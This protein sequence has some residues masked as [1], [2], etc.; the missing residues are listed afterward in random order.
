M[1]HHIFLLLAMPFLGIVHVAGAEGDFKSLSLNSDDAPLA[2]QMTNEMMEQV[3]SLTISGFLRHEDFE[4]IDKCQHL[5]WL[6]LK[7]ATTDSI[8]VDTGTLQETECIHSNI[9]KGAF[10]HAPI[11]VLYLPENAYT[12][13]L[14]SLSLFRW[15][16]DCGRPA[17]D[18]ETTNYDGLPHFEKIIT[19]YITGDFPY[20]FDPEPIDGYYG[21]PML[22]KLSKDNKK[23]IE[24]DGNIYSFNKSRLLKAGN[25]ENKGSEEL[26]FDVQSVEPCAFTYSLWSIDSQLLTF[27]E[28]LHEIEY[29]AFTEVARPFRKE[30]SQNNIGGIR[31]EGWTPPRLSAGGFQL[32]NH[33]YYGID[34]NI[35]PCNT[36]V[37]LKSR[38]VLS[39]LRWLPHVMD[40]F[41]YGVL[42]G[43]LSVDNKEDFYCQQ[44]KYGPRLEETLEKMKQV[45]FRMEGYAYTPAYIFDERIPEIHMNACMKRFI[46]FSFVNPNN[47]QKETLVYDCFLAEKSFH[48][49]TKVYG[50]DGREWKISNIKDAEYLG[51]YN[52]TNYVSRTIYIDERPEVGDKCKVVFQF[53]GDRFGASNE[54]SGEF[55][56]EEM[57][58]HGGIK[59]AAETTFN[60][61]LFDLQGRPADGGQKGIV[62]RDGKK[63][64]VK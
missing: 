51:C 3:E 16:K 12:F 52:D 13:E 1:K 53:V 63:V 7:E 47:G 42:C 23:C 33:D 49:V 48:F 29:F 43:N 14:Q 41:E 25:L 21:C 54:L 2:K 9:P 62:I 59:K 22:F 36:I 20:L 64:L 35:F 15:N 45:P 46:P 37:P 60:N 32:H 6:N 55:T 58:I 30:N 5:R 8:G 19:I 27:S 26:F 11:E 57:P 61:K 34:E 24:E 18:E 38:Y 4:V 31:F 50:A 10:L 44:D 40:E 28:N 56:F 17:A 39:D